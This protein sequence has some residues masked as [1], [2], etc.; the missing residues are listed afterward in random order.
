MLEQKTTV[1]IAEAG[2]PGK[3]S[4]KKAQELAVA[5]KATSDLGV[6]QVETKT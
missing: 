3:E 1:A 5:Q 4:D 6:R 2:Y